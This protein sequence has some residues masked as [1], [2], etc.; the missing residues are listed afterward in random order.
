MKK[1]NYAL[2][3]AALIFSATTPKENTIFD[4]ARAGNAQAIRQRIHNGEDC[5][6]KDENGNTVLHIASKNGDTESVDVL[7]TEPTYPDWDSRWLW[8]YFGYTP[9]LPDPNATN[10]NG[11]TPLHLAM[12][13]EHVE[14]SEKLLE[15]GADP[16]VTN[17]QDLS[18]VFNAIHE[19]KRKIVP[20]LVKH[21][22]INQRNNGNN[23]LH[24]AIKYNLFDMVGDL[25]KSTNLALQ[26]NNQGK[27]PTMVAAEQKDITSLKILHINGVN[28]NT[29]GQYGR[30]PI[31]S[32]AL[33]GNYE[34]AKYLL[35]NG[36]YVDSND[37]NDNTGL[38]LATSTGDI[39]VVDLFLAYKAD[40]KK[41]NKKGEDILC[42]AVNNNRRNLI[43]RLKQHPDVK[44]DGRDDAGRTAF[45]NA[46]IAGN[47]SMMRMLYE[48]GAN[49]H[50]LDNKGENAIHKVA[51]SGD[52]SGL[53]LLIPYHS[54]DHLDK[55]N[56]QGNSPVFVAIENGNCNIVTQ[57]LH[58]G[59]SL[60]DTNNNGETVFHKIAQCK[61]A[62]ALPTLLST[63]MNNPLSKPHIATQAHN[64]LS[65]MHYASA[66]D[67]VAGMQELAK[68][69]ALYTDLT[70]HN[71]TLA[72]TAAECGALNSL[73]HL[74]SVIPMMLQQR[75][76][77]NHTP[78]ITSAAKGKLDALK[79]LFCENDIINRDISA[80][81]SIARANKHAHIVSFLEQAETERLNFCANIAAF[82]QKIA[83]EETEIATLHQKLIAKDL[84]YGLYYLGHK[85]ASPK[86]YSTN[87]LY[88]KTEPERS[89]ILR[90]YREILDDVLLKKSK[91]DSKLND[92]LHK[93]KLQREENERVAR[94]EAARQARLAEERRQAD[95]QDRLRRQQAEEARVAAERAEQNRQA[96]LQEQALAEEA[97]RL[98]VL[99][100]QNAELKRIEKENEAKQKEAQLIA[101]QKVLLDGFAKKAKDD[102]K[103]AAALEKQQPH[104]QVDVN[105]ANLLPSA[106]PMEKAKHSAIE[107]VVCHGKP[108]AK[109]LA[110]KKCKTKSADICNSCF[111]KYDG[112]C[113]TCWKEIGQF[114]KDERGECCI[115]FEEKRVT[116]IPCKNCNKDTSSAR[117]CSGC[118]GA[119]MKQNEK[120]KQP[121]CCPTCKEN[122]LDEALAKK[123]ATQQ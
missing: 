13:Q 118:I 17:K 48:V 63:I 83:H 6:K 121:R 92:I 41:R 38:L 51:L 120:N 65:A 107:C 22:L 78:F 57:L 1:H 58:A 30:Q 67:N 97:A 54:S 34:G 82:P 114:I 2:L 89:Q 19:N 122:T 64:G 105:P 66:N 7:T 123:L 62:K 40:A 91:L 76:K 26:E 73:Q 32:A 101:E 119:C 116:A 59:V 20:F 35:E 12:E 90:E 61:N 14:T 98:K 79:L 29:R 111:K 88:Y 74:K 112:Q 109:P 60:N 43:E 81:I 33:A 44:I 69:H 37:N 104:V 10:N 70:V 4:D 21:K 42:I 71:D 53:A 11:D 77:N 28:L 95:L 24:F 27:T 55:K 56:H 18:P 47:H 94:E 15:K 86:Q 45:M 110:C 87:D 96:A 39:K 23:A 36:T 100:D 113:P 31:H 9:V 103:H 16:K 85:I 80:A 5:A 108:S 102:A 84:S 117:I 8:S 50:I 49:I 25:A 52:T 115:C 3:C 68:Y 106:P 72:H 93:E 46:T 99:S 75:N